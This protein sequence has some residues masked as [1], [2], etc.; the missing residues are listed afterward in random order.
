MVESTD[1]N[2]VLVSQLKVSSSTVVSFSICKFKGPLVS[3]RSLPLMI[4]VSG[5]CC[6]GRATDVDVVVVSLLTESM[7]FQC[8]WAN[9]KAH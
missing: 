4:S 1:R 9:K 5:S 6:G 3:I 8:Q 2:A 7:W